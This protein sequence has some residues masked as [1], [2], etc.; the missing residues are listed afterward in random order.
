MR[1][2]LADGNNVVE[3]PNATYS[4]AAAGSAGTA[5]ETVRLVAR[6]T[7]A[8]MAAAIDAI[9]ALLERARAGWRDGEGEPIT[10]RY[11]PRTGGETYRSPLI[12]GA[13]TP[14]ANVRRRNV[15]AGIA[16]WALTWTREAYWESANRQELALASSATSTR[17]G[18][19]TLRNRMPDNWAQ[20]SVP[21]TAPTPARLQIINASGSTVAWNRFYIGVNA[22]NP[23]TLTPFLDGA[24]S[25]GGAAKSWG[26][27]TDHGF[28]LFRLDLSAALLGALGG[29]DYR[30][31]AAFS[32]ANGGA[33]MRASVASTLGGVNKPLRTG[34][35]VPLRSGIHERELLDLGPL[36]LPPGGGARQA[37]LLITARSSTAG[38]ATLDFVHL[39]PTDGGRRL[40]QQGF[41][42]PNNASIVDDSAT[43]ERYLLSGVAQPVVEALSGPLLLWPGVQRLHLLFDEGLEQFEAGRSVRLRAWCRPRWRTVV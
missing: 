6:G 40:K 24:A 30:V 16:E 10:I 17:T 43:D 20:A 27:G 38:S 5:T 4:P 12:D 36:P 31:L 29:R 3:V 13:L 23:T 19:V 28:G 1:L 11:Q 22:H 25:Q 33:F 41:S 15:A 7:A 26:A 18:G 35:E 8:Q 37:A 34:R 42:A 21:G 14:S 2:W 39:L 9:E 32:S